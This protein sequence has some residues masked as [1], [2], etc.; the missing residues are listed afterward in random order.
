MDKK[1]EAPLNMD[2][3]SRNERLMQPLLSLGL[4]V[5]RVNRADSS[6]I[7]YLKVTSFLPE[8]QGD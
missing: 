3:T 1:Q 5:E 8:H 7:D 6:L 2:K 4:F